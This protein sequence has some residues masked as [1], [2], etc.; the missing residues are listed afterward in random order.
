V[1]T[2]R[3]DYFHTDGY[4][5]LSPEERGPIDTPSGSKSWVAD[6]RVDY[7]ASATSRFNVQGSYLDDDRT[8]GRPLSQ[9]HMDVTM[10]RG[11]GDFLAGQGA[12]HFDVFGQWRGAWSTRGNVNADH[13]AET[14]SRNQYDI[15]SSSFGAGFSWTRAV[16]GG[17]HLLSAGSD[18][19]RTE[20]QVHDEGTYRNGAFTRLNVTG[21]KQLS[22][23]VYAQDAAALGSRLRATLGARLDLWHPFEGFDR[24][25]SVPDGAS[26]RD[27][28]FASRDVWVFDPNLGLNFRATRR[29]GLRGSVYRTFRAPTPN[30]LYKPAQV[31][32]RSVNQS[33]PNL[34]P[35]RVTVGFD[36]GFDFTG[37]QGFSL[38]GTG[39]WNRIED[40]IAD[41]TVKIAGPVPEVIEPCGLILAGGTCREKQNIDRI[42]NRG[43]EVELQWRPLPPLRLVS[44][45]VYAYSR[46]ASAPNQPNLEGKRLRRVPE[47]QASLRAEYADPRI[48]TVSLQGRYLGDRYADDQNLLPVDDAVVFD[49]FVSR[50]ITSRLELYAVAENLFDTSFQVDN[51]GDAALEYGIPRILHAGVRF[52]WQARSPLATRP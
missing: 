20:G 42:A 18:L 28:Q 21:G 27:T 23:G 10:A 4:I 44:S 36:T 43:A 31:G 40:S 12:V 22:W 45:Y 13:T 5:T 15:P 37:G 51:G 48:V 19:L 35:E 26:L 49:L 32:S 34:E 39:F 41:V 46:V 8:T 14:P 50:R 2:P 25:E 52:G 11:G 1:F 16:G 33:N 3:F 9:D 17:R 7:N 47:H 38:R 24:L 29:L 30:E 6:A